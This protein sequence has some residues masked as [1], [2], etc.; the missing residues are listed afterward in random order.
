MNEGVHGSHALWLEV[1]NRIIGNSPRHEMIDLCC[2]GC[3]VTRHL[4]FD[5]KYDV[6][7]WD[8]PERPAEDN[9][10]NIDA[11]E[12][13]CTGDWTVPV[14]VVI[15]SDGLEHFT[16][17]DACNILSGMDRAAKLS[18]VFVP[19]NDTEI[20]PLSTDPHA[21]KSAWTATS[22]RDMGYEVEEYPDWH[23]PTLVLGALFAW[24]YNR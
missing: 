13:I 2:G 14:D 8:H 15:I 4:R 11:R 17:F 6:D 10:I 18:I 21:H 9:F 1:V 20:T 22:F 12:Y 16:P 3:A 5:N 7:T 23:A 24:K 19:T